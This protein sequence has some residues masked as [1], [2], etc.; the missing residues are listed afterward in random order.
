MIKQG[1][2]VD[3]EVQVLLTKER[4]QGVLL[5]SYRYCIATSGIAKDQSEF[6]LSQINQRSH[7]IC[8]LKQQKQGS[9]EGISRLATC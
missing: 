5:Y 2:K 4:Y 3:S 1:A 8:S 9:G 7:R 6:S